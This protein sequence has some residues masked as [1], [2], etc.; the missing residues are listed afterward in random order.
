MKKIILLFTLIIYSQFVFSQNSNGKSDD[1]A[2][3]AIATFIPSDIGG[4]TPAAQDAL[5]S[6]LDRIVTT[7]GLGGS[8]QNRFVLTAKVVEMGKEI[9]ATTP[10]IYVFNLDITFIIGDV[11][12]GTLFASQ[13]ISVKGI[14]NS[15]TKAYLNAI[16]AIKDNDPAYALFLDKGK[17]KIVEYY[18][19]QCDF[20]IKEASTLAS[21]KNYDEAMYK[22]STV[23][24]VCKDCFANCMDKVTEIYKAKI[25]YECQNNIAKATSLMA[26]EDYNSAADLLSPIIPEMACY[27]QAKTLIQNI[28]DHKCAVAIGNAKGSWAAHDVTATSAALSSIPSDSKCYPE[29]LSLVNE[30]KKYV[31][32]T[33]N[34]DFEIMKQSKQD[35]KEVKLAQIKAARDVGVAYGNNQP[36]VI[37]RYSIKIRT[38]Y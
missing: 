7:N 20:I 29:A 23:P 4:L 16:K 32:E 17:Q 34:R 19:A 28:N 1:I 18:N 3:I 8:N 38:W 5:K 15:E 21:S 14:G 13:T 35:E 31:K 6:R 12:E 10:V 2:R 24:Q 9:S 22:L 30:V 11:I 33:E 37:N 25:E 36:K 27:A 26:K